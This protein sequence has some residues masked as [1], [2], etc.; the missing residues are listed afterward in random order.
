MIER[1]ATAQLRI[2]EDLLDVQ[3]IVAGRLATEYATCDLR[4]LA[5]GSSIR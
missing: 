4:Q 3:R 5:Q 2:V 1:N